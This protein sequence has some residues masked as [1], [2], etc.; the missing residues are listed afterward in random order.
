MAKT[1]LQTIRFSLNEMREINRYLR[2]NRY[3]ESVSSLGRVAVMEL[4][5]TQASVSLK[6]LARAS[7]GGKRPLFLWDYDL[8]EAQV[9]EILEHQPFD[10]R[11][12]LVARI[13]ERLGPDDVFRYLSLEEI[14]QALPH[15]RMNEK[16]KQHWREAVEVWTSDLPV[17]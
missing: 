2:Q 13:L 15:L 10:R 8:T 5:H 1:Q 14:S 17:S 11:K 9:H 3:F 12:W 6:P 7:L 4:I 16:I